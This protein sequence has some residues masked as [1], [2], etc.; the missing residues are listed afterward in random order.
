MML[1]F[2][3]TVRH[4]ASGPL[5]SGFPTTPVRMAVVNVVVY[6]A[7]DVVWGSKMS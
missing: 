2:E 3:V 6:G 7:V 5:L 1:S 4:R